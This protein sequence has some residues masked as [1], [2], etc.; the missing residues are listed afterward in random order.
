MSRPRWR[1]GLSERLE[2]RCKVNLGLAVLARR[3]DGYHQIETVMARL[4]LADEVEVTLEDPAGPVEPVGAGE[5]ARAGEATGAE[6]LVTLEAVLEESANRSLAAGRPL[7][8]QGTENLM[9]RAAQAY[10]SAWSGLTGATPPRVALRLVKRVPLAA[11]LGG[12]SADAAATLVALARSLPAAIDLDALALQ[13]GSDVPFFVSGLPAALAKG[14][15]GRLTPVSVPASHLVL[16]TPPLAVTA[17]EGY[18]SLVGF[19]PRLRHEEQLAALA[20]GEEP[21]WR[22]GLQAGVMRAYP[23]VREL[24]GWMR[25]AG[26]RG[27]LM[28]GSGP[29]CFGVADSAEEAA[30]VASELT[31]ARPELWVRSTILA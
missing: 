1:V 29:T 2:A 25:D 18:A 31:A 27:C 8:P 21:G 13:L 23:V 9:V 3:G 19:T 26:L 6:E 30:R 5:P 11:G 15:G 14:R 22:N 10:L 7:L 28:S 4:A 12:G 20:R 24:L 17:A 16:A